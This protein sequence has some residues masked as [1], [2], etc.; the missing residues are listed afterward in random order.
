MFLGRI[1]RLYE[2]HD[3]NACCFMTILPWEHMRY[4]SEKSGTCMEFIGSF[5]RLTDLE[6]HV[7]GIG[8][9]RLSY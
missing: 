1:C 6:R 5:E 7:G 2:V 9:L 8:G 4:P 3:I